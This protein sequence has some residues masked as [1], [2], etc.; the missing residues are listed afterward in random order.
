[1][2][3]PWND[4]D[5]N[6]YEKH[7]SL[8][9]VNQLQTMNCIMKKQFSAYMVESV[10]VLGVASGNGLEHINTEKIK[11]VYGVDIN[12]KYLDVCKQ[13]Y[14]NLDGILKTICVD[15]N[16][17]I[18]ILPYADLLVANL[19]IEYIGYNRFEIIVKQVQPKYISCVIQVN[20][21]N[22]FVSNS[23]YSK[24]FD[25]LDE[26]LHT[27]DETGLVDVMQSIGYKKNQKIDYELPNGKKL[28]MLDFII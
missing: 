2:S 11:T 23:P 4:I 24:A 7:M 16:D 26:V 13:R 21:S 15:L 6:D 9:N 17:D 19:L 5:L 8:S 14:L 27:I 10:M 22:V 18:S 25:H 1:M 3:N 28:V 20:T 12:T